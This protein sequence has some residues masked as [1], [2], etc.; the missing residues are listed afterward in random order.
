MV[1][2]GGLRLDGGETEEVSWAKDS[3][4]SLPVRV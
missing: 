2:L 4:S 3:S 1:R